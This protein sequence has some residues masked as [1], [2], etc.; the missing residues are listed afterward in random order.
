MAAPRRARRYPDRPDR[1]GPARPDVLW[2]CG[3]PGR[4]LVHPGS[5][6]GSSGQG[7][8]D[9]AGPAGAA[10][11]EVGLPAPPSALADPVPPPCER[12][13]RPAHGRG[14]GPDHH[15][16]GRAAPHTGRGD[17]GRRL[18]HAGDLRLPLPLARRVRGRCLRPR[19]A[20]GL[21]REDRVPRS[22]P[23]EGRR[24]APGR[25]LHLRRLPHGPWL[26]PGPRRLCRSAGRLV[27]RPGRHVPDGRGRRH[28]P[29]PGRRRHRRGRR[30]AALRPGRAGRRRVVGEARQAAWATSRGWNRNAAITCYSARRA[31]SRPSPTC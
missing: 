11:P 19:P 27:P 14:A 3:D 20:P 28:R 13:G 23:P 5:R 21:W 25:R 15:R 8:E 30:D 29:G 9:A 26:D 16:H 12:P 18:H 1:P 17:A 10:A 31:G 22:R 2:Q 6:A 24:P 7:A 4:D